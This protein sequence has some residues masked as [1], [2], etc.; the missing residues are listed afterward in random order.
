M[1]QDKRPDL[2]AIDLDETLIT[3]DSARLAYQ[4]ALTPTLAIFG[5]LRLC[6]LASMKRL[7][8]ALTTASEKHFTL[9]NLESFLDELAKAINQDVLTLVRDHVT[10]DSKGLVISASPRI[11]VK[12]F[13]ERLGFEG[14]GS[15]FQPS[16][17]FK[18][19]RGQGKLDFMRTY[20]PPRDY[21]YACAISDSLVDRPLFDAFERAYLVT[22]GTPRELNKGTEGQ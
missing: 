20:Y 1:S 8:R 6:N 13:A 2:I 10:P 14:A 22:D 17:E 11:Y 3:V 5:A 9:E 16:G 15:Y 19:L 4:R 21:R 12:P 7:S 18:D